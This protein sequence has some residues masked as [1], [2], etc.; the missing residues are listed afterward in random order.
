MRLTQE[1]RRIRVSARL[2][3][4]VAV[5]NKSLWVLSATCRP[6]CLFALGFHSNAL[7]SEKSVA[8]LVGIWNGK[9]SAVVHLAMRALRTWVFLLTLPV[10]V[11]CAAATHQLDPYAILRVYSNARQEDIRQSY[12]TLCLKYHP[13]KNVGKSPKERKKCEDT[14]K[15][16]QKA[17]S[18][19]GDP[20]SRKNYD[21]MSRYNTPYGSQHHHQQQQQP[22]GSPFDTF[23]RQ[24]FS[25]V[26]EILQELFRQQQQRRAFGSPSS[27][28]G[29]RAP[30]D[31]F[32]LSRFK[33]V[34]VQTVPVSLEDLFAGKTGFGISLKASLWQRLTAAFRGGLAWVLL[35]QSALFALPIIRV[36]KVLS[37]VMGLALF[38]SNI[39]EPS[40]LDFYL[41]LK[42]GYKEGTK[43]TFTAEG[44]DAIFIIK[45]MEHGRYVRQGN[46]LHTTIY[47]TPRQARRGARVRHVHLDGSPLLVTVPAG[48]KSGQIIRLAEQGWL[49]RRKKTRG[50]LLVQIRVHE[51]TRRRWP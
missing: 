21:I 10:F 3:D 23:H 29:L 38:H 14:F 12:R 28:F 2:R 45:E 51:R 4:A 16:I 6:L 31:F 13:D 18:L 39:P 34:Y 26:D 19:V 5:V 22:P 11:C 42:E 20:E 25:S 17:Y 27:S 50:S 32:N 33:S 40:K 35:Y 46:D 24:R 37:F 8:L 44:F 43:F 9:E 15:E 48:S 1:T 47:V 41:N 7:F 30:V 36:S 49:D